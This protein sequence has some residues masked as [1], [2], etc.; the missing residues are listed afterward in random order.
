MTKTALLLGA[1]LISAPALAEEPMVLDAEQLD[2]VTAGS[3]SP[4]GTDGTATSSSR[5][6]AI[7]M[8]AMGF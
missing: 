2:Q 6:T 5:R 3:H 8:P 1:L 7:Q 4:F